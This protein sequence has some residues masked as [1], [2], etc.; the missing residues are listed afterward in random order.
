MS[1]SICNVVI[2]FW[3]LLEYPN[4]NEGKN[5]ISSQS[6]FINGKFSFHL[7]GIPLNIWYARAHTYWK[8][9]TV[10]L[11]GSEGFPLGLK[12]KI[13]LHLPFILYRHFFFFPERQMHLSTFVTYI[14]CFRSITGRSIQ[15]LLH[16]TWKWKV[17]PTLWILVM[18]CK[19]KPRYL[20]RNSSC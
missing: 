14:S 18:S 13:P 9:L 1:Y 3:Q 7:I 12:G 19:F 4:G 15:K 20:G 17:Q 10:G 11:L 5:S 16:I 2:Y 6:W 8:E